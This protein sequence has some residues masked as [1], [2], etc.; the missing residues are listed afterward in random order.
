MSEL[1]LHQGTQATVSI[2][3]PGRRRT[4]I[5]EFRRAFPA[6]VVS[7]GAADVHNGFARVAWIT[8]WN[9]GQPPLTGQDFV[10]LGA[11]GRI[12]LL[13]APPLQRRPRVPD[14][15]QWLPIHATRTRDTRSHSSRTVA[16]SC[17]AGR[18][19]EV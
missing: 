4:R 9:N 1:V 18:V 5:G 17:R 14:L 12:Q 13:V 3:D 2:R 11:D 19:G 6:A 15:P 10:H 16:L 7:F 8:T